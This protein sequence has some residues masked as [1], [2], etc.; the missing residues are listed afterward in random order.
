MTSRD[1]MAAIHLKS[2]ATI[3]DVQTTLDD[4][5][6]YVRVVLA[7]MMACTRAHGNARVRIGITGRGIV[8]HH[9][10]THT[11]PN[12]T[13]DLFEAYDGDNKF[14]DVMVRNGQTWSSASMSVKATRS[15]LG[16]LRSIKKGAAQT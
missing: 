15:L 6:E 14:T 5:E 10:V 8:P 4:P 13:E 7:H 12:A 3:R 2:D 11:G 1:I 9:K 16:E